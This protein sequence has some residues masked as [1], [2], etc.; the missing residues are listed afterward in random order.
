MYITYKLKHRNLC[1]IKDRIRLNINLPDDPT[2][3][4]RY[5]CKRNENTHTQKMLYMNA[6]SN[7]IHN[8]QELEQL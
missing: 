7:F 6:Y 4:P 3:P 1:K 5:L 2:I 8:C